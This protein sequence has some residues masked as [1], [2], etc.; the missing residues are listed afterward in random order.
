MSKLYHCECDPHGDNARCDRP[1]A[2][3][4]HER[5]LNQHR[6]NTDPEP[7]VQTMRRLLKRWMIVADSG[8]WRDQTNLNLSATMIAEDTRVFIRHVDK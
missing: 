6:V 5:Q 7:E 2:R 8:I 4:N 3:P 1:C